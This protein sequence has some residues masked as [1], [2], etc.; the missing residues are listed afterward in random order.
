M[1]DG[2][3]IVIY[4]G[5]MAPTNAKGRRQGVLDELAGTL[6]ARPVPNSASTRCWT[7]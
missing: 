4:V 3:K 2:G 5:M 1:P 7:P 6:K